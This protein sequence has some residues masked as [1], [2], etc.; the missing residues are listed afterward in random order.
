MYNKLMKNKVLFSG[1]FFLFAGVVFLLLENTFYQYVDEEGFLHESLFLPLGG[2]FLIIGSLLLFI[3]VIKIL[4]R[5]LCTK[6]SK[7]K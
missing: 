7:R 5:S 2:I 3:F 4:K 6:T 1:L